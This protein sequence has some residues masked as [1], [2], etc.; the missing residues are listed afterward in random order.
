[1]FR[2]RP[3]WSERIRE[4]FRPTPV[5]RRLNQ[6]IHRLQVQM[7]RLETK[8]YQLQARDRALYKKCV[9]AVQ[10]KNN[11]Q[12]SMYAS[13]CAEI[14]KMV[15][16]TMRSQMALE[17]VYLRLETVRDFGEIA[18]AMSS[19]GGVLGKVRNDLQDLM[20]DIST[21]LAEVNDELQSVVLEVGQ[22]TEQSFDFNV[23]TEESDA[24]LK[25]AATLAE[26]R[27]RERFPEMPKIPTAE[28]GSSL[29]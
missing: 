27:M 28:P 26:Q 6:T 4:A 22:A 24:I 2:H 19:V 17:R 14:R 23:P 7:R 5:K 20:P 21:E 12:A 11:A 18:Y 16:T 9:S 29:P 13:E 25:E 8:A 10:S 15:L 1:M 3:T